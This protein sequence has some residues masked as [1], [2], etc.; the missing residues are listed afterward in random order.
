MLVSQLVALPRALRAVLVLAAAEAYSG[1]TLALSL[2]SYASTRLGY[3]DVDAGAVYGAWTA[4]AAVA[5]V[6]GGPLVDRLGVRR[7]TLWGA[8]LASVA[9]LVLALAASAPASVPRVLVLATLLGAL[10]AGGVLVST[11]AFVAVRQLAP[12]GTLAFAF[13]ALYTVE[14]VAAA[15]VGLVAERADIDMRFFS[16]AAVSAAAG[17][18][19]ALELPA[20]VSLPASLPLPSS[21]TRACAVPAVVRDGLF[22]RLAGTLLALTGVRGVM[23]AVDMTLPAYLVRTLGP[24]HAHYGLVYA[25]NPVLVVAGTMAVQARLARYDTYSVVLVGT[26][27]SAAAPLVFVVRGASLSSAVLFMLVQTAGELVY[28]PRMNVYVTGLAPVD[29]VA[30]YA[31]A[32]AVPAL[33]ARAAL[34]STNGVLLDAF[35]PA[36]GATLAS[37]DALWAIVAAAGATTCIALAL[38]RPVLYSRAVQRQLA[39]AARSTARGPRL[40]TGA[41]DD[42]ADADDDDDDGV[43][44]DASAGSRVTHAVHVRL[45]D[46][47]RV[48]EE[49]TVIDAGSSGADAV[50]SVRVE[51]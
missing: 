28:S 46:G 29:R 35:C 48:Y 13:A 36:V 38:A 17:A 40:D 3:S 50:D 33:V 20:G 45:R 34:A 9:R 15:V 11:A 24:E 30:T 42:A 26:A 41:A 12:A 22:W 1:F 27:L 39:E 4:A 44:D 16:A 19:A 51:R 2:T 25:L 6:A 8:A 14:N 7:A 49:R 5:V 47:V 21:S 10:P 31:T 37:C 18:L 43:V 23:R 32:A